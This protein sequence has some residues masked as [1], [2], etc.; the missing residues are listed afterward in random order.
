VPQRAAS[1]VVARR[2]WLPDFLAKRIFGAPLAPSRE[3][4]TRVIEGLWHGDP[5]MDALVEWMLEQPVERKAMFERALTQGIEQVADAPPAL[6]AFFDVIDATP[7]WVDGALLN[8]GARAAQMVGTAGFYVLRDMA[9]MGGYVYFNTMNQTLAAT[10]AL[11]KNVTKRLGE[12]GQWLAAAVA[13]DGLQ[14]FGAGFVHTLRVRMVHALVRRAVRHK[15]EWLADK[16][17]LPINQIELRS[18]VAPSSRVSL[19]MDACLRPRHWQAAP[20][21]IARP[22]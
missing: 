12:T 15:P 13:T 5:P 22:R 19:R 9:L 7:A 21:R 14:R 3:E 1:E 6:R 10:G 17:G 20:A 8:R 2:K 18:S 4:W 11:T 16:W